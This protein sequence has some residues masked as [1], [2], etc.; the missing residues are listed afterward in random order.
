MELGSLGSVAEVSVSGVVLTGTSGD[1][2]LVSQ[3]TQSTLGGGFDRFGDL[4]LRQRGDDV[5]IVTGE[6]EIWIED[7]Q[8]NDLSADDI[9]F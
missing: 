5:L 4:K 9:I 3:N 7:L 1:D 6:G 2:V 8:R